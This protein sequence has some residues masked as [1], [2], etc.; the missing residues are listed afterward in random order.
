VRI[1]ATERRA[2]LIQAALR[3]VAA[4]GVHAA[5]TRA[6]VAEANMSLAS[7]HYA[8]ES[9]DELMSELVAYVVDQQRRALAPTLEV[10]D[11]TISMGDAVRAGLQSYFEVLRSDPE[12][13]QAM[14]ELTQYALRTPE[15]ETLARRQYDRYYAFAG[16]ALD[17]A[18]EQS[19]MH[20]QLPVAEVAR[21]LV[22]FTDGLTVAWLVNRDDRAAAT[23]MDF[24]ADAVARLVHPQHIARTA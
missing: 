16:S 14:L 12:R 6:I 17:A 18:A 21:L 24:A 22:A 23:L 5:T 20:W 15:L 7:F 10:V 8:F 9:R 1:P 19:G 13:E 3:V 2:A 4:R 11:S